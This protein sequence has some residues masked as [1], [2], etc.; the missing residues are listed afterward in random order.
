[1]IDLDDVQLAF[2]G[3]LSSLFGIMLVF[4]VGFHIYLL[5]NNRTYIENLERTV[6]KVDPTETPT[7]SKYLNIFNI[8]T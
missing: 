4:F 3:L 2:L 1:M 7:A 8:G 6:Y 5:V